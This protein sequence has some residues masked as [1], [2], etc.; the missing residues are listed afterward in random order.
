MACHAVLAMTQV[1][2]SSH[3]VMCSPPKRICL[4]WAGSDW[5]LVV[6]ATSS[7][8]GSLA[9]AWKSLVLV[10]RSV[11]QPPL[12][13]CSS[14]TKLHRSGPP[15]QLCLCYRRSVSQPLQLIRSLAV[16]VRI[17]KRR[18]MEIANVTHTGGVKPYQLLM[19]FSYN[20]GSPTSSQSL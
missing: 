20:S 4:S 7:R 3:Q 10:S 2:S 13:S 8:C 1:S 5:T 6:L 11:R 16:L 19:Q 9:L 18:L 12:F 14:Y 17:R 15:D